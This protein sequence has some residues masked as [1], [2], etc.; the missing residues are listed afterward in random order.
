M[1]EAKTPTPARAAAKKRPASPGKV[2]HVYKTQRQGRPEDDDVAKAQVIG[3][4]EL[5]DF[6][7]FARATTHMWGLRGALP[8]PDY[9]SVN[10]HKA[11]R[12][13]TIVRWAAETGRLPEWLRGEGERFIPE[14]GPRLRRRRSGS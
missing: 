3:I 7:G 4:T 13:L 2:V 14:G 10:G 6:L 8:E 9:R 12:R 11:W 1:S 5:G